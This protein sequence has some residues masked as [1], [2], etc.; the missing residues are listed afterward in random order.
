MTT[1]TATLLAK[2]A[3]KGAVVETLTFGVPSGNL[4]KIVRYDE[5]IDKVHARKRFTGDKITIHPECKCRIVDVTLLD[6]F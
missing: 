1:A 5:L 4:Y 3:P 2:D 6:G